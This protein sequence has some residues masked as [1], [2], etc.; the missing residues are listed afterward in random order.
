MVRIQDDPRSMVPT[1]GQTELAHTSSST[2]CSLYVL[3]VISWESVEL[4]MPDIEFIRSE[5][6]RMRSQVSRQRKEILQ[7]Q[8]ADIATASAEALLARM[9]AKI[10]DLCA[11]RD[12]LKRNQP[13]PTRGKASGDRR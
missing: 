5:I 10:D 6:E 11:Q 13:G 2:L 3:M 9:L 4:N 8:R 1:V 12:E 7:L